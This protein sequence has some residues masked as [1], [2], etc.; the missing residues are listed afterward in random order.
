MLPNSS[1]YV[2]LQIWISW[3]EPE[4]DGIKCESRAERRRG[5][6]RGGDE[7]ASLGPGSQADGGLKNLAE[8]KTPPGRAISEAGLSDRHTRAPRRYCR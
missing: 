8:Q 3:A 4:R 6:A 7:V 1:L 2:L 5:L